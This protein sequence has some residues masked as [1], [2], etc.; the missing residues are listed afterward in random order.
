MPGGDADGAV[1]GGDGVVA[2]GDRGGGA[3]GHGGRE[4][5]NP[6]PLLFKIREGGLSAETHP[7]E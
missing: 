4:P 5:T 2:D 3:R 6:S 1:G 7:K